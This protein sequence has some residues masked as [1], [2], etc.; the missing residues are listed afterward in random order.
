MTA[1]L[2]DLITPLT[3]EQVQEKIYDT[4][5]TL[6]VRTTS[7]KPGA[8]ARAIITACSI[9]LASFTKLT[10]AIARSGFLE[11]AEGAWLAVVAKQVF[12]V[13][14]RLATFA[15]GEVTL[16]N[17]GGGIYTIGPYDLIVSNA[18]TGA[19]YRNTTGFTLGAMASTTIPIVA[20]EAGAGSS[21]AAGSIT[22]FVTPLLE[23]TATNAVAVIGLDDESD[24]E[25]RS[26]C[27]E[28]LGS[29]SPF[30][31][32]DAYSYAARSARRMDGS[33]VAVSRVRVTKDGF[34]HVTVY[35]AT[36]TGT[37]TGSVGDLST[38]LGAVDDAVQK[39]AAPL[40]MT[41]TTVSASAV[42]VAIS[43][44]LWVLNTSK[45]SRAQIEAT[46]SSRLQTF[47]RSQPIGGHVVGGDPGKLFHDALVSVIGGAL[48]EIIH[49]QVDT[50][51]ADTTLTI[52]QVA[53]LGTVTY[54]AVTL[55]APS[56]VEAS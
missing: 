3:R 15:S 37:V 40:A 4:L 35:T 39:R 31:P 28:K 5:A 43:V 54:V 52:G 46:V 45:L 19:Q 1:P 9:V 14:K 36:P 12:D 42:V 13:D 10:A 20:V 41:A 17:G 49:V 6:G 22:E 48:P 2:E 47:F 24:P 34:G 51:A 30:G 53:T 23:V 56:G 21:S 50:P 44:R 38:D 32:W 29:L 8:V 25:L 16:S 18:D 7:W 33:A 55:V 27:W 26:R 11:Y